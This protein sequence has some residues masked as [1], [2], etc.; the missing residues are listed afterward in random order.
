MGKQTGDTI[1]YD[2]FLTHVPM[3][4]AN[5]IGELFAKTVQNKEHSLSSYFRFIKD[6]GNVLHFNSKSYIVYDEAG[7]PVRGLGGLTDVTLQQTIQ[8][9]I[10]KEKEISERL[11]NSLPGVF[12]MFNKKGKYLKWNQNI[13]TITGYTAEEFK[14]LQP[15][16]FVPEDTRPTLIE[17]INNVFE[18]GNDSIEADFLTKDGRR[19]PYYFTGSKIT[20]DDEDCLMGVGYDMT[21]KLH[22]QNQLKDLASHLQ[23]VR[24]EEQKRISREIHDQLGQQLTGIKMMLASINKNSQINQ[25][26]KLKE[27]LDLVDDTINSVRKISMNLRPSMLDDL[28]LLAAIEWLL[29]D[30]KKKHDI[31]CVFE[32]NI[33]QGDIDEDTSSTLFRICQESITNVIRHAKATLIQVDLRISENQ[34]LMTIKDDGIGID[35]KKKYNE[36]TLG[37][38]GMKERAESIQAIFTLETFP[39]EGTTVCITKKLI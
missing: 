39:N 27:V 2:E 24:E 15:V 5:K 7:N 8:N 20:I 35:A 1:R 25:D 11:I 32:T 26:N 34:L 31:A 12:Y 18:R 23:S 9:Q 6:D 3:E 38:I 17:K 22:Y 4:D 13:L 10:I 16:Q 14:D 29:E 33:N 30:C 37:I 28:G 36:T 21:E 19:L